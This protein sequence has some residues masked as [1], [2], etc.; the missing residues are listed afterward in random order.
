MRVS[1]IIPCR[2]E[3]G[4]LAQCLDSIIENSF[5]KR[6][7]EV[8]VVD[9]MSND[10]TSKIAQSYAN[11]YSYIRFLKNPSLITPVAL[12]IGIR[13]SMGM[14][15]IIL[16]SHSKIS[17]DF[18]S[19][20]VQIMQ[21]YQV[22]CVGGVLKTIPATN[23]IKSRAIASALSH[24]FGIGN[25]YFRIGTDKPRYVDTVPFGC[26]QRN[27]FDTFGLFDEELIRNQDD[28]FNYRII[29]NGGKILLTPQIVSYYHARDTFVKLWKMYFQYGYFKPRVVQKLGKV[30][31]WRQLIPALFVS[32]LILL[33]PLA[34]L[35]S[36]GRIALFGLLGLYFAINLS[37]SFQKAFQGN[38]REIA[39][40][41]AAF[42]ILHFSYGIGYMKG[43]W[44]FFIHKAREKTVTLLDI[45]PNR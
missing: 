14:Y 35:Y 21:H 1:L 25:S 2:N 37:I 5:P 32:S 27:T 18:I 10:G 19:L 26:Y 12:N 33:I 17:P 22:N 44:D 7:L 6:D 8:L 23:S 24:P 45:P 34:V 13:A 30:L 29:K 28:E 9:G 3:E 39:Y 20:N 16:G 43:I 31:S 40:L 15:I 38:W 4:F 36:M 42:G 11:T 41:P